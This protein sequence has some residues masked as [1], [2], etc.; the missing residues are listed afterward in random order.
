MVL[1]CCPALFTQDIASALGGPWDAGHLSPKRRL[2]L[3]SPGA[4]DSV[5]PR[6]C[7]EAHLCFRSWARLRQC[8][9]GKAPGV[10]VLTL[11]PVASLWHGEKPGCWSG[12]APLVLP[13]V[14]AGKLNGCCLSLVFVF[15][16][17]F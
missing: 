17:V 3:R 15:F 13:A 7:S 9:Q 4:C 11:W 10:S 12:P 1:P 16:V 5:G 2:V 14:E 8:A 6:R